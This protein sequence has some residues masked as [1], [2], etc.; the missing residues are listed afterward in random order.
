[1]G[2]TGFSKLG[3]GSFQQI[4]SVKEVQYIED[5]GK[6]KLT[7]KDISEGKGVGIDPNLIQIV[8]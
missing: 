3:D 7:L 4:H 8:K 6:I 5:D 1:M 2:V